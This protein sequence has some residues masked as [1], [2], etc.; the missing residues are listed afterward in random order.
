MIIKNISEVKAEFSELLQQ[1]VKG[2]EVIIEKVGVPIARI[3]P[4]NRGRRDRTPGILKGKITIASDFD[5]L[6]EG[7]KDS[8]LVKPC[9]HS[10]RFELSLA[11]H[12]LRRPHEKRA[13]G[14]IETGKLR[15][16]ERRLDLG[17]PHQRGDRQNQAP[18]RFRIDR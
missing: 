3:V 10:P 6:P 5:A 1:V 15:N 4:Y 18:H 8:I 12:R 16:G 9:P 7:L 14:D 2:Y 11:R 13:G 17:D